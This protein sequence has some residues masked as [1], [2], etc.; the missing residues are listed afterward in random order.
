MAVMKRAAQFVLILVAVSSVALASVHP[1][2][3]K[4]DTDSATCVQCHT[5]KTKGKVVHPAVTMG[6]MTCHEVRE[7][8]DVTRVLLKDGTAQKLCTT[9]HQ[10]KDA[11]KIQ[12]RVHPPNV[13]D[14]LKCHDPH[15]S[16][17]DNL[18]LKP[19]MGGQ[20]DNLCL[21]CHNTGVD[22]PKGGSRHAA[23]D[24]GCTTCHT[25]H[26]SGDTSNIE[27]ADHLTKAPPA[28]CL[29]CHDASDPSLQ[30]A[31]HGQ[32]FATANCVQCHDP[33]QSKSPHLLQSNLHFPFENQMCDTCHQPAKDGKVVLTEPDTRK[34]CGTCHADEV[35][36]IDTAKVQH[37]GAQGEC[38]TCHNPH[39]G[40]NQYFL[41]PD[42]VNA[43]TQCHTDQ[44]ADG[45]KAYPHQPAFGQGCATCHDAH[46]NSNEHLLRASD[47]NKLCLECH[48]PDR[49]PVRSDDGKT[50]TIFGGKVT[51]P[52]N[53]FQAQMAPVLPL[54][55]GLGHPVANHPVS[56]YMDPNTKKLT[57]MNCLTCHQPHA[58]SQPD[59]LIHDGTANM[60]FCDKCHKQGT[61]Q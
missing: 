6:C 61:V 37:P 59:L 34:L 12:G 11:S 8:R 46:G 17:N 41:Q 51:L 53:Y 39:A 26:K 31:H 54:Q 18:L 28:L 48:G 32:P 47:P 19:A 36:Q 9:C 14:C 60:Q 4:K 3:L 27:F 50:L 30:K 56:D 10:D 42:P 57:K 24:M 44:A 52:A 55:D 20:G 33:H 40:T 5:D 22:V 16:E 23:L 7:G 25:I 38:T 35:K 13:R 21:Q 29:D 1:V 2:P 43:C 49:N 15:T 58:S 45:K